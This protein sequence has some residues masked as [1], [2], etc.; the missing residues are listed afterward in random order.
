MIQIPFIHEYIWIVFNRIILF[1]FTKFG[2][3]WKP[4][5]GSDIHDAFFKQ[6]KNKQEKSANPKSRLNS[7]SPIVTK[8]CQI[9][10]AIKDRLSWKYIR[11]TIFHFWTLCLCKYLIKFIDFEQINLTSPDRTWLSKNYVFIICP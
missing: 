5:V 11:H 3:F 2:N 1:F 4:F 6:N 9:R 7:L 8:S 10:Y